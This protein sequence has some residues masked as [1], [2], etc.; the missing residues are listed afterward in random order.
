[1]RREDGA[2]GSTD[3]E[4][5]DDAGELDEFTQAGDAGVGVEGVV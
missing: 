3:E 1:M 5:E 4:G 2:G